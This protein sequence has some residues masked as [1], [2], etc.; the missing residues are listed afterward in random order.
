MCKEPPP[1]HGDVQFHFHAT[2]E[3]ISCVYAVAPVKISESP[4]SNTAIVEHL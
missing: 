2:V 1:M 3:S 4:A